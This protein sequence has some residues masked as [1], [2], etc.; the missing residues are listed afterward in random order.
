[1]TLRLHK[2]C[3]GAWASSAEKHP[4]QRMR[5]DFAKKEHTTLLNGPFTEE[6]MRKMMEGRY[7]CAADAVFPFI[8]ALFARS[9]GCVESC[10][11]TRANVL[12]TELA[13]KMFFD[14]RDGISEKDDLLKMQ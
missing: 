14:Y 1:M 6:R 4:V 11:L 2:G 8:E 3:S 12:Y 10:D 9:L 7:Y 13:D 5:T